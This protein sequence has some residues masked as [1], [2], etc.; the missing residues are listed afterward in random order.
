[1]GALDFLN[2]IL[3]F[4]PLIAI[5][6]LSVGISL[7][8]TIIYK[9]TTNQKQMKEIKDNIKSLQAEMKA[10][11]EP[12]RASAI[13]K[14]MMKLS[15][16]QMSSSWK[17]TLIFMIPAFMLLGWMGSHLAYQ[18]IVPSSEFTTTMKL[19]PGATGQAILSTDDGIQFISNSTQEIAGGQASWRMKALQEGIY[20]LTFSFGNE[21]YTLSAIVSEKPLYA[22][23]TLTKKN[24]LKKDS[25]IERISV[26]LKSVNPFGNLVVFGW[27][28][29]W[30]AT[31]IIISLVAS[32]GI[33]KIMKVY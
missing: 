13:Q 21:M 19:A 2:I 31:Y 14:E 3:N 20:K 16:Q 24:G 33:R 30:L 17:S 8:T 11:K 23:P 22:N 12:G 15:M 1:M 26:D 32:L 28:P 4:S 25:A 18:H 7:L 9:Y 6:I 5:L 27:K 29:G 10:T